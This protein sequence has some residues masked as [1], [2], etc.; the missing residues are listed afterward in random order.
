MRLLESKFEEELYCKS[1]EID[2]RALLA[3]LWDKRIFIFFFVC[4]FAIISLIYSFWLPNVY[5][6]HAIF[7]P[8]RSGNSQISGVFSQLSSIPFLAGV[9]LSGDVEADPLEVLKA[10][11]NKK[12]NLRK[13]IEK[14]NLKDH[15][16]IDSNFEVDVENSYRKH[17]RIEKNK[18]TGLVAISFE[19]TKPKLARDIVNYNLELLSEISK[20]TVITENQK[21]KVF[22]GDRLLKAKVELLKIEDQIKEYEERN[23][24]LSIDSQAKATIDAASKLQAEIMVNRVKLKVKM[25]L[26]VHENHP[27]VKALKLEIE[28]LEKQVKQIEEG[29]LI[30]ESFLQ[31]SDRSKGLTYVPLDKIPSLKLDMERLL[32][33][34]AVQQEIYKVLSKE[35][36]LAK[37]ESSKDQEIIEVIEWAHIP[38][39][40][41]KPRRSIICIA[42][43]LTSFLLACFFVLIRDALSTSIDAPST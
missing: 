7:F 19:A 24:I 30:T 6:S 41:T 26:G 17:L 25:E 15:Y 31:V 14:Y 28:A 38:E 1:D 10:H 4:G 8:P 13:V 42:T 21:K 12:E 18:K 36:E 16:K 34:K 35:N 3:R 32:R 33:E 22:L 29:G 2:I 27:E 43:T 20:F 37:I 23:Q 11:L 40:K 9:G 5:K 39:K